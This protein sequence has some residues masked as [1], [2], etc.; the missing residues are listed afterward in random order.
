MPVQLPNDLTG[1][2]VQCYWN[3][4]SKCWSVRDPKTRLVIGHTKI[5]R[6]VDCR[7]IVNEA[8][9]RRVLRERKKNVHAWVEG[10]VAAPHDDWWDI[11]LSDIMERDR[12]VSYNPYH[13]P[14]F[15]TNFRAEVVREAKEVGLSIEHHYVG[16][17]T[18]TMKTFPIVYI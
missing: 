2:R 6:L 15:I 3:I 14:N 12:R 10:T 16:L 17:S 13:G 7:F 11:D 9:R 4:R 8:G 5:L 1:Q 18:K